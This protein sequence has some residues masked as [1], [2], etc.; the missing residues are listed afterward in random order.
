MYQ[1]Y[2]SENCSSTFKKKNT[3]NKYTYLEL[4][5]FKVFTILYYK[6]IRVAIDLKK[7]KNEIL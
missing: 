7:K 2:K 3:D 5:K 1:K 4:L 6:N